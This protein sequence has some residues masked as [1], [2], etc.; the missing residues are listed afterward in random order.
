MKVDADELA[1]LHDRIVPGYLKE[2]VDRNP[3]R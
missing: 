2:W 1:E 3:Y